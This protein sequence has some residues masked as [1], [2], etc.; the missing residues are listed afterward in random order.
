MEKAAYV[1]QAWSRM[2]MVYAWNVS[3]TMIAPMTNTAN[4]TITLAPIPASE[5]HVD[6]MPSEELPVTFASV[7][8]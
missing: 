3:G 6:L 2:P 4:E 5:I 7:N 1:L 8:V